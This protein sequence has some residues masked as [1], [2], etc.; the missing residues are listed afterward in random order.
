[1]VVDNNEHF[2]QGLNEL[3]GV[4]RGFSRK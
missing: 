3:V 2:G 4:I 1:L